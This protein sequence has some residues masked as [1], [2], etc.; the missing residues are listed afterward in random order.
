VPPIETPAAPGPATAPARLLFEFCGAPPASLRILLTIDGREQRAF[1]WDPRQ[2]LAQ[3]LGAASQVQY[4]G[5]L[6][7]GEE[8]VAKFGRELL[9]NGDVTIFVRL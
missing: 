2:P 3:A 9:V 5:E 7:R 1:N 6:W 8:R 4:R